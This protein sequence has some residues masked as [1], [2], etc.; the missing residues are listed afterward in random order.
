MVIC[1]NKEKFR[2]GKIITDCIKKNYARL[3]SFYI[4]LF[5]HSDDGQRA[6]PVHP[7]GGVHLRQI[8]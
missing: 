3:F 1:K 4:G 5:L 2:P 7:A 6:V 8:S